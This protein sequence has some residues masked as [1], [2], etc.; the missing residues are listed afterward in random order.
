[1]PRWQLDVGSLRKK[2]LNFN[3]IYKYKKILL[4]N[5]LMFSHV[6]I[7]VSFD[8]FYNYFLFLSCRDNRTL[9]GR[10]GTLYISL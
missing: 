3:G 5:S 9:K 10:R 6:K 1:M 7:K 4:L 2:Y 8:I